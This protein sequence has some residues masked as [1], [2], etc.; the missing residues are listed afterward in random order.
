MF[1]SSVEHDFANSPYRTN[2]YDSWQM[3]RVIKKSVHLM[4]T[5]Q[6]S[7]AQRLFDRP[8]CTFKV[9][10]H[11]VCTISEVCIVWTGQ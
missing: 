10:T 8:V 4:T 9:F 5:I 1:G 7:G 2:V 11:F 3:Y 6:S